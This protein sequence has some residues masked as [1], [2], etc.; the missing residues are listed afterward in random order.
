MAG[1]HAFFHEDQDDD[2]AKTCVV[3]EN[4]IINNLT[5]VLN[6]PVQDYQLESPNIQLYKET[7]NLTTFFVTSS[8]EVNQLFSRPPPYLQSIL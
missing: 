7:F 1:I 2:H 5:P 8:I 3:C 6:S 4:V